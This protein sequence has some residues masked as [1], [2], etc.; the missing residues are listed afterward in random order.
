M[1]DVIKVFPMVVVVVVLILVLVCV[2]VVHV[3]VNA[4]T[5]S[6]DDTE[7]NDRDKGEMRRDM[8]TIVIAAME[9]IEFDSRFI[10]FASAVFLLMICNRCSWFRG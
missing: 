6:S 2:E 7:T 9:G 3:D 1:L 10:F 4:E 8:A 5:Y